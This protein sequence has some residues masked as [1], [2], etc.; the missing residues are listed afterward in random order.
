MKYLEMKTILKNTTACY[1]VITSLMIAKVSWA[2]E[3]T[4]PLYKSANI[5]AVVDKISKAYGSKY[6]KEARNLTIKESYK[7]TMVGQSETPDILNLRTINRTAIIDFTTNQAD[8]TQSVE[9]REITF[10]MRRIFSNG[11]FY[12]INLVDNTYSQPVAATRQTASGFAM[13]LNDIGIAKL[14]IE[15]I[16]SAKLLTETIIEAK[17]FHTLSVNLPNGEELVIN[18]DQR[19]GFIKR[20]IRQHP[21]VGTIR[22]DFS[23]IVRGQHIAYARDTES[24]FGKELAMV[25]INREIS[26]NSQLPKDFASIHDYKERSKDLYP[27]EMTIRPLSDNVYL[28]GKAAVHSLFIVNGN[29]V[30]GGESYAGVVDRF[31]ALKKYLA[32]PLLLTDLVVT[33]HH[34]DHLS[35]V[36]EL[37]NLTT[38]IITV[39]AHRQEILMRM[40]ENFDEKRLILV[41]GELSFKYQTKDSTAVTIFDIATA[42]SS[43]NL[44]MHVPEEKLIYAADYYRS[45]NDGEEI[46]GFTDLINFRKA[47]DKLTIQTEKFASVHGIRILTYQ[48]LVDAT[49]NYLKFNCQQ[50]S[51]ICQGENHP[52]Y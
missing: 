44:I 36:H 3:Q 51:Y 47:I 43:H 19:T 40:P 48:Q 29:E 11:L 25:V 37:A 23:N 24:Y 35:G 20:T 34:S 2:A 6:L 45:S 4:K 39:P 9:Q 28:V 8:V 17:P 15:N 46:I 1:L 12:N 33:H 52:H 5:K 27:T 42:H 41:D 16:K 26:I 10:F 22:T 13:L 32:K 21:S 49:D 50:Y 38:N 31:N 14:L 30:I 18:I 7:S